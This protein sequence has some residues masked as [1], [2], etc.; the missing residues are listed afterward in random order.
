MSKRSGDDAEE[1]PR[2]PSRY[3][4]ET[5]RRYWL[6]TAIVTIG[7][8]SVVLWLNYS[9]RGPSAAFLLAFG[10]AGAILAYFVVSYFMFRR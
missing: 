8:F 10:I 6:R 7:I 1:K 4:R 2:K 3:L 9:T 5:N